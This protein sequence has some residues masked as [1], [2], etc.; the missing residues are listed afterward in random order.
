M[1]VQLITLTWRLAD[2]QR[3]GVLPLQPRQQPRQAAASLRG[4]P[5]QSAGKD[6]AHDGGAQQH[7]VHEGVP[8]RIVPVRVLASSRAFS[9]LLVRLDDR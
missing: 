3:D 5:E 1:M 4:D 9:R 7:A 6:A 2:W 8:A